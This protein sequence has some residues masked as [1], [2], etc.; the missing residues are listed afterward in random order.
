MIKLNNKR[1]LT[2]TELLAVLVIMGLLTTIAV[3]V[4]VNRQE[5]ARISVA[6]QETKKIAEAEETVAAL[7]GFYVPFQLLDDLPFADSGSLNFNQQERINGNPDAN[8][9]HLIDPFVRAFDQFNNNNQPLLIDG[10]LLGN[11]NPTNLNARVR[12]MV[13]KWNG[14]YIQFHRF[15]YNQETDASGNPIRYDGPADPD[16]MTNDDLFRDFPLDPWGNPY[17]FYSAVG[18]VGNG[19]DEDQF[20]F[21][22]PDGDFSNGRITTNDPDRFDRWAVVSYGRDGIRDT[23]ANGPLS[24]NLPGND[25]SYQ[26]G[27]D[28][29]SKNFGK[30]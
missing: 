11:P 20:D 22:T 7:H 13:Q 18:V 29:V 1:G 21:N 27:S 30:F 17:R 14:P 15:W 5:E 3:P 26:F 12:N 4:Y 24:N 19:R 6:R 2:L 28:G 25:I 8:R 9:I 16:Y 10:G 23:D